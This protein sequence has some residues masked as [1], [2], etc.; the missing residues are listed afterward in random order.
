MNRSATK[1]MARWAVGLGLLCIGLEIYARHWKH[2]DGIGSFF[3]LIGL[4][5]F[6]LS[7]WSRKQYNSRSSS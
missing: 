1:T 2:D 6:G 4:G 5:F 3:L 7:A